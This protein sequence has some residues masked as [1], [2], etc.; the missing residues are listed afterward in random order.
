MIRKIIFIIPLILIFSFISK[1]NKFENYIEEE[2]PYL[3]DLYID[4]HK[5][6]EISLME[7]ETSIKLANE[8]RKVGFEV[9]ENFG[10]SINFQT[11]P[12]GQHSND[13]GDDNKL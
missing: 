7:K 2:I 3:K 1:N 13:D 6:P 10:C 5:N 11:P 12:Q 8:L 4:I 9:E